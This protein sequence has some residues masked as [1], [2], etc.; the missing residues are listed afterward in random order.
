MKVLRAEYL[1]FCR[2]VKDAINLAE[3]TTRRAGQV[4]SLGPLIH[5]KQAVDKL[6]QTGLKVVDSLDELEPGPVLIR[7]HGVDPATKASVLARSSDVV[8]ATCV[9]VRR[10]QHVVKELHEEGYGVVVVG[11]AKHPEVEGIVGYAPDV[12]V[13]GSPDELDK[14]PQKGRLGVVGQTTLSQEKFA[15]MV[16]HIVARSFCEI[17]V[18]NTL[19]KEVDRRLAAAVALCN[20]VDVVFVLGGLHSSNTRQ[21]AHVCREQGTP[22]Y[23]LEDWSSFRPDCVRGYRIAGVTA[24][25]STPDWII[26]EFVE[27]LE[28][29]A[30]EEHR[31]GMFRPCCSGGS[32]S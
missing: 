1:G 16:G 15:R 27:N 6:T 23:H 8:D 31:E 10:A 3:E 29:F 26:D 17:K 11:D 14:L 2:G 5:N 25:A 4:C 9:L 18:V 21:L 13:V 7:A 28:Q 20:Q 24:G 30:A 12:V 32:P 22:T 19:C